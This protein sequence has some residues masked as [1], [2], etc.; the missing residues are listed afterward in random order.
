[1]AEIMQAATIVVGLAGSAAVAA[2]L[3]V[4]VVLCWSLS[5]RSSS[6]APG[7][8]PKPELVET[9][10]SRSLP[11][12]T[13]AQ[14]G[15]DF[16]AFQDSI[17]RECDLVLSRLYDDAVD[18]QVLRSL[19]EDFASQAPMDKEPPDLHDE[20][21][22]LHFEAFQASDG[23]FEIFQADFEQHCDLALEAMLDLAIDGQSD[24]VLKMLQN[25]CADPSAMEDE[26]MKGVFDLTGTQGT[27][28]RQ[29]E[30]DSTEQGRSLRT[31]GAFNKAFQEY[32][33]QLFCEPELVEPP[34]RCKSLHEMIIQHI[35]RTYSS[36]LLLAI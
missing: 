1:M 4:L 13:D 33:E 24:M 21:P 31:S 10:G 28:S 8:E 32:H 14:L 6:P 18:G 11:E 17:E 5:V 12:P 25:E 9:D 34:V 15:L 29:V 7:K 16:E 20:C 19:A 26:T 2:A 35:H 22:A 23:D 3:C 30:D 36:Y 27:L